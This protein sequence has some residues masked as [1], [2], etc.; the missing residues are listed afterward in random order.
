MNRKKE[1]VKITEEIKQKSEKQYEMEIQCFEKI[2]KSLDW[3]N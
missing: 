3:S 2:D 1:I